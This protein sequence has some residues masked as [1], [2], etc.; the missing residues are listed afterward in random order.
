[1]KKRIQRQQKLHDE[2][3][4]TEAQDQV[5]VEQQVEINRTD[6]E[7]VEPEQDQAP[8]QW[9]P[10][11]ED[12]DRVDV[13]GEPLTERTARGGRGDQ[14]EKEELHHLLVEDHLEES[15]W[16]LPWRWVKATATYSH[17]KVNAYSDLE[18]P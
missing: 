15:P 14:E 18:S 7:Q 3:N 10:P 2:P 16:T 12:D 5:N 4:H 6:E 9:D 8:E 17:P 13:G 1:M 11:R